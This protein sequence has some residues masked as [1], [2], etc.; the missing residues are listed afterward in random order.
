VRWLVVVHVI[1]LV[2]GRSRACSF[3]KAEVG[4]EHGHRDLRYWIAW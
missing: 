1:S 2:S 4:L 3:E